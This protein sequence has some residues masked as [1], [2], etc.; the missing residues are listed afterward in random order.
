[1]KT[2]HSIIDRSSSELIVQV[3]LI[4]SDNEGYMLEPNFRD[5]LDDHIVLYLSQ[6]FPN[7]AVVK[8]VEDRSFPAHTVVLL[9]R[10]TGI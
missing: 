9:K 1:M 4:F 6:K 3:D 7:Y 10:T 5:K 2:T 8:T